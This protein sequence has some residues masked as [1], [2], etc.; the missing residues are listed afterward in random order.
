MRTTTLLSL[1]TAGGGAANG[2]GM[3]DLNSL[4]L[5]F[6]FAMLK[7]IAIND[8]K[9]VLVTAVIPEPEA[10]ALMLAGLVLTGVMV[11]RKQRADAMEGTVNL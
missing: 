11:R 3:T 1:L 2:V 5:S 9:Q 8:K 6:G 7:A 4:H 10:Y